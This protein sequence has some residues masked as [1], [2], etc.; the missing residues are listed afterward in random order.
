MKKPPF[1][2]VTTAAQCHDW[3]T[4]DQVM[5]HAL[6]AFYALC[7]H[8]QRA[9][10]EFGAGA[11]AGAP[12]DRALFADDLAE[13]FLAKLHDQ[14]FRLKV[15]GFHGWASETHGWWLPELEGKEPSLFGVWDYQI[16]KIIPGPQCSKSGFGGGQ[17]KTTLC[18]L[19][20]I[21]A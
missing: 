4:A 11:F 3:L 9:E 13:I 18:T 20:K 19:R 2:T 21:S 15:P 1:P 17:Y 12:T 14:G 10:A 7:Q 5:K 16:N 6:A 8:R